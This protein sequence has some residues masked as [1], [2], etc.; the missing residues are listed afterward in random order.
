M[1]QHFSKA[2]FGFLALGALASCAPKSGAPDSG[3]AASVERGH[4]LVKTTGCGD[5]HTPWVMGL[6]GP[7]QD[8]TRLL[9]GHPAAMVI[10]GPAQIGPPWMGAIDM[11]FTAFSG[12][13]GVSFTANLTPDST[14][15]GPW[16]Q[17][18][19]IQALRTGKHMG[20]GRP[21]LPP[22]PWPAFSNMTDNDLASIYMYLRTI[23]AVS[24]KVPE[25]IINP[26][27]AGGAPPPPPPPGAPRDPKVPP[28]AEQG[29][30]P[31]P[32][33]APNPH[34]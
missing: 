11:S 12:P 34:K 9:S 29:R 1:I 31:V 20:N 3:G 28:T 10:P 24:N 23:P 32:Q 14:G 21:I 15:L 4:Y 7:M 22:M 33:N 26:A 27:M 5:C 25:A 13:W 18:Q 8:T 6:Q 30:P 2:L 17:D 19:F 16:S